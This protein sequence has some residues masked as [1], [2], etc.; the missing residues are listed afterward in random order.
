MTREIKGT[1]EHRKLGK[2]DLNVSILG[3]GGAEIGFDPNTTQ[4]DVDA[5]L[6]GALDA[7]LNLIDTA[8]A[9]HSSEVMIGNAVGGARRKEF[10][11]ITKCGAIDGFTRSDWS[12]NGIIETIQ[13]SLKNL[14]T[15]YLDIAQLHS[16]DAQILKRGEAV[17]A[18]QL[19]RERGYTRFIGYSGDNEDAQYAIEMNVFDTLQTSVSIADQSAIDGNISLAAAKN[20]G[21]I[22]KRPVA[23]AV[24]RN[25]EKPKDAYHQPYWE[26][27]QKLQFDFLKL[28][29]TES[30]GAAL[31][32]TLSIPGVAT[33][34]V[35]TTKP[36][37]WSENAEQV[38][39]GNLAPEEFN[40]IR[41]RWQE[42]ADDSWN[43]QT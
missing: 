2:T 17:E 19:A 6:G 30:I 40:Q 3:F 35:G 9:Y 24:W 42:V 26:R 33:A 13:Q 15:D 38:R 39:R 36:G 34:I 18:L 29:L 22:A 1:M 28:P 5:M 41:E 16:C 37:R 21:I 31:R 10:I 20:L 14:K 32:F 27:I 4:E 25:S 7:G 11:L 12:K 23:N 43:G 8:A